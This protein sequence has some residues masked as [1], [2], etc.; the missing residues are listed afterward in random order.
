MEKK[1]IVL[2]CKMAPV[3]ERN[4]PKEPKKE[5]EDVYA[6]VIVHV[7]AQTHTC[8]RNFVPSIKCN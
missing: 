7:P 2:L 4:K 5:K 3:K 1:E 6:K 8:M